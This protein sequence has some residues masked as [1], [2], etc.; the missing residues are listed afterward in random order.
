MATAMARLGGSCQV[1]SGMAGSAEGKGETLKDSWLA[2]ATQAD[3]VAT[4]TKDHFG[5]GSAVGAAETIDRYYEVGKLPKHV[6]IINL[7]DGR[8]EHPTQAIGDLFTIYKLFGT[9]T[10]LTIGFV[11]DHE[12]YR[13][14]HSLMIGA[15]RLG[16]RAVAVETSVAPVPNEYDQLFEGGI[17]RYSDL[18]EA[19]EVVDALYVGRNPEE[20]TGDD[21]QEADRSRELSAAYQS[22]HISRDRLQHMSPNAI[23]MHPR[24]I[25]G[26]IDPDVDLDPRAYDIQQMVNMI[27]ARAAILAA[28]S[29]KSLQRVG[30][31]GENDMRHIDELSS[32]LP[33]AA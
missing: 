20:Y 7:G 11:G 13:A 19:M 14:H 17:A 32:G 5:D 18:D 30:L 4:R 22:W 27:P 21:E 29:G 23:L 33:K 31:H 16:M 6:P 24:P 15:A 8:N 2:F 9:F 28:I 26:E 10:G 3:I 12:R 1:I 25:N